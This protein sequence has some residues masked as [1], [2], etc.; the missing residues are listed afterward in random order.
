MLLLATGLYSGETQFKRH[1]SLHLFDEEIFSFAINLQRQRNVMMGI[2]E[3]WAN[4]LA[5][6]VNNFAIFRRLNVIFNF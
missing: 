5:C 2:D 4:D 3:T 1:F 6:A